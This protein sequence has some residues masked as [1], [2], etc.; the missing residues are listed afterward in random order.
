ME[1]QPRRRSKSRVFLF[2]LVVA[3]LLFACAALLRRSMEREQA[4][5]RLHDTRTAANDADAAAADSPMMRDIRT[6]YTA[7][8]AKATVESLDRPVIAAAVVPEWKKELILYW[9]ARNPDADAIEI[10]VDAQ[11]PLRLSLTPKEIDANRLEARTRVLYNNTI[12]SPE[13]ERVLAAAQPGGKTTVALVAQGKTISQ[14]FPIAFTG[15]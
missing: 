2:A 3:L 1:G 10:Q 6:Q 14:P 12:E 11:P 15:K 13:L 9:I 8:L 5:R 7:A 4:E